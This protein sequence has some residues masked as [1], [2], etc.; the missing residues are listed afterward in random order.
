MRNKFTLGLILLLFAFTWNACNTA[1]D[2]NMETKAVYVGEHD[3][4]WAIAHYVEYPVEEM[5]FNRA[6]I[7]KV[8][9]EIDVQ[10]NINNIKADL[11]K[12]VPQAEIAIGR[13]KLPNKEVLPLNLAVLESLIRSV[14]KLQYKPA[15]KNGKPIASSIETS[16]EFILI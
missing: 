7:V 11:D 4:A 16:V 10:G 9:F 1:A 2:K 6:G 13:K 3:M 12:S 15:Q 5:E 14:E 8:S